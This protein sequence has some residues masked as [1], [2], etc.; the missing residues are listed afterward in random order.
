MSCLARALPGAANAVRARNEE[1]AGGGFRR[2]VL[3][4]DADQIKFLADHAAG[5]C[6][7]LACPTE[8][9]VHEVQQRP[10]GGKIAELFDAEIPDFVVRGNAM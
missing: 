6:A 8:R 4:A 7:A 2:G 3:R 10:I 9:T 5:V 1:R